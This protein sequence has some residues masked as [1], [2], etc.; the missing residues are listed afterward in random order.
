M[1]N[2]AFDTVKECGP[3]SARLASIIERIP[4]SDGRFAR[5]VAIFRPRCAHA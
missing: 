1:V 4:Y 5:A 3:V 2:T